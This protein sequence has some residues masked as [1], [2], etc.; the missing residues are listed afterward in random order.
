MK[1]M[2]RKLRGLSPQ[3][4]LSI[5]NFLKPYWMPKEIRMQIIP[6]LKTL[7]AFL[8]LITNVG[9]K[10]RDKRRKKQPSR[11]KATKIL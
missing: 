9:K 2:A 8:G 10:N 7:A 11:K 4:K 5:K 3:K 6:M 1:P